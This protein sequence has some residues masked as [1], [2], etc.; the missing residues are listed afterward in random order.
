MKFD[1]YLIRPLTTNDLQ[2]YFQLIENNR[3]RLADFFTGT[4]SKTQTLQST[5][6][7]LADITKNADYITVKLGFSF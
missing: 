5:Q 7:F 3:A 4:V 1:N 2:A 6:T